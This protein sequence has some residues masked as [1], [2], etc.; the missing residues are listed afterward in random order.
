M[1]H[2]KLGELTS[3]T[4]VISSVSYPIGY[5]YNLAG[6]VTQITYP[7]GRVVGQSYDSIGRLCSVGASGSGCT[8]GTLYAS[9]F[10][11]NP[12][13]QVTGFTYGNGVVAA[14]GYSPDRLLL[15]S[16]AHTKGA[17]TLFSTNYWR[18]AH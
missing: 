3:L 8:T 4:K 7:S 16:L 2:D 6:E 10:G 15:Q 13:M 14:F 1:V 11:Y 17:T 18:V 12:A 5:A 9:G